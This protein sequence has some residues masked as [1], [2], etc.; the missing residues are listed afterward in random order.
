MVLQVLPFHELEVQFVY[1]EAHFRGC[2]VS[3]V[4]PHTLASP[5]GYAFP[6]TQKLIPCTLL[7]TLVTPV[8]PSST[9]K[10]LS[11]KDAAP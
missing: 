3:G 1:A 2:Q 5:V 4:F 10:G 9:C 7:V 6:A 8:F 11:G